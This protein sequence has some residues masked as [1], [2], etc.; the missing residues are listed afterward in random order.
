[1]RASTSHPV[2]ASAA[3]CSTG[4]VGDLST[5]FRVTVDDVLVGDAVFARGKDD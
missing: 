1:M 3:S 5:G 2:S 4:L